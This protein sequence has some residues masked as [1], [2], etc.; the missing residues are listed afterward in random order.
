[1]NKRE[2]RRT[3]GEA[4]AHFADCVR[5]AEAGRTVVLTRHGRPVA[6][7]EPFV[8]VGEPRGWDELHEPTQTYAAG[9]D[10]ALISHQARRFTLRRLLETEIWPRIPAELLG[11]GF[12]K[13]EREKILGYGRGGV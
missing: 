6:R 9:R 8:E 2:L 4:K 5:A 7:I 12:S 10:E 11:K 1:V 13:R 3:L